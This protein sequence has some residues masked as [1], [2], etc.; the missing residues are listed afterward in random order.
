MSRKIITIIAIVVIVFGGGTAA[1]LIN[2]AARAFRPV[3]HTIS[4]EQFFAVS[5][6]GGNAVAIGNYLFF[7][8]GFVPLSEIEY[9]D[10][11]HNRVEY[12][13]IFRIALG[14][15]GVP[16]YDNSW[17]E[18]WEENQHRD[19]IIN[20]EYYGNL[21]NT[22]VANKR[23]IVP[24]IAGHETSSMWIFGNHIIY[25]SPH[26][27]LDRQ[28]NMQADRL[29]FFRVDLTGANHRH[30]FT[31][32]S[33]NL[34][35]DDFTV[36]WVG[37]H[38]HLLVNDGGRLVRVG[39]SRDAGD[40]T[41][42]ARDVTSFAFPTVSNYFITGS[43]TNT[44]AK[45]FGGVMNFVYWTEDR[46][47]EENSTRVPAGNIMRRF[48][49][50]NGT[51]N[52]IANELGRHYR[53]LSVSGGNLAFE[54]GDWNQGQPN[55]HSLY[56]TNQQFTT[57]AG[58]NIDTFRAMSLHPGERIFLPTDTSGASF[59]LITLIGRQ[60]D[61]F[62]RPG[63]TSEFTFNRTLSSN[64]DEVLSVTANGIH[65]MS[66][67]SVRF[68]E[69]IG[70]NGELGTNPEAE[71]TIGSA[72]NRVDE[73]N[74]TFFQSRPYT[75]RNNAQEFFFFMTTFTDSEAMIDADGEEGMQINETI[76]VPV[77]VDRNGNQ[78]ILGVIEERFLV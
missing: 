8:S 54:R 15:D 77:I 7:I 24:K 32:S 46:E 59:R 11:E 75:G 19:P 73:I 52:T 72:N 69:F 68:I 57:T 34:T 4:G 33:T 56:I 14:P 41:T 23:L 63:L 39:V 42:I 38:S 45:G 31:T 50:A 65:Y 5:G 20:A 27:R 47:R 3:A 36:A 70:I 61:L 55:N 58:Q 6:N 53:V 60:L 51:R 74:I 1:I 67:G 76:S 9:R 21:W 66:G 78:W 37:G 26:N 28:G 25:T 10:N 49:I 71:R 48:N 13:G 43:E 64:V 16:Q 40:V 29:D 17:L 2:N 22:R 62:T 18:N 30:L 35:R 12:G 44:Q